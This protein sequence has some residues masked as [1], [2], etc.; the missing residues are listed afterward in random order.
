MSDQDQGYLAR[1]A[2]IFQS[3]DSTALHLASAGGHATVMA[4]LISYG[5]SPTEEDK[6]LIEQ[7]SKNAFRII[8]FQKLPQF[9]VFQWLL[10]FVCYWIN[11]SID[12]SIMQ[13]SKRYSLILIRIHATSIQNFWQKML[14]SCETNMF[15]FFMSTP[16]CLCRKAWLHYTSPLA[17]ATKTF[18][19]QSKTSW[20]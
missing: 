16:W 8:F 7:C 4:T 11:Q 15:K 18:S 13:F 20:H 10:D 2:R 5:A 19:M 14:T 3:T 17:K 1:F 9:A 12:Q 6:V